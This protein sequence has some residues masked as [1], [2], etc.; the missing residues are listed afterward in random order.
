MSVTAFEPSVTDVAGI[1]AQVWESFLGE[2]P[3]PL[4]LPPGAVAGDGV[5]ALV[6]ISGA[7]DGHVVLH[8]SA[9]SAVAATAAFL[10]ADPPSVGTDDVADAL[11]ELANMVG[12][13]LKSIAPAPSSLSL[14]VVLTGT[15]GPR[16][17][18]TTT[19]CSTALA[20]SGGAVTLTV[21]AASGATAHLRG[22]R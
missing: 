6:S 1:V 21:L 14:P 7:W 10:G 19:V 18:A 16:L 20:R 3:E 17:P 15:P 4:E 5:T 2:T 22:T 9:A 8:A 13:Y 12:G 11:G